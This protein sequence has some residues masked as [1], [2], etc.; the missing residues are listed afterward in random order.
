MFVCIRYVPK[1]AHG[2]LFSKRSCH[3]LEGF[4]QFPYIDYCSLV[5]RMAGMKDPR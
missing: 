2:F 5:R 1:G 4:S 3:V